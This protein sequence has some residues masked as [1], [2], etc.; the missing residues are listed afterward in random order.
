MNDIDMAAACCIRQCRDT[1]VIAGVDISTELQIQGDQVSMALTS[2]YTQCWSTIQRL[3][4]LVWISS[5][6]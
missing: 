2:S 6:K 4:Q 1:T 5:S 3:C